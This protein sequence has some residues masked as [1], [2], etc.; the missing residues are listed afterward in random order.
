MKVNHFQLSTKCPFI[1]LKCIINKP[2]NIKIILSKINESPKGTLNLFYNLTIDNKDLPKLISHIKK[3]KQ[4]IGLFYN[5]LPKEEYLR[6]NP[7]LILFPMFSTIPE[8][9]DILA[10]KKSYYNMIS[11]LNSLPKETKKPIV[12][13]VTKDNLSETPDLAGL[14]L[15]LKTNIYLQPITFFEK[16]DFD[17]EIILYLKRIGNQKKIKL[18]PIGKNSAHCMNWS[19]PKN[20][21]QDTLDFI[22]NIKVK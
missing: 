6:Y 18:L 8:N 4:K 11:F 10:G 9:H 14:L 19:M 15:S 22:L 5:G 16:E 3:A 2:D 21:F 13:F 7:D 1:C 17:N 20:L 12:F